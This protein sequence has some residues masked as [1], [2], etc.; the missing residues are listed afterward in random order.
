MVRQTVNDIRELHVAG[1]WRTK[2]DALLKVFLTLTWEDL[3]KYFF[4]YD[5]KELEKLPEDFDIRGLRSYHVGPVK[6][7]S[8]GGG[9]WHAIREEIVICTKGKV[10]WEC[11]DRNG[12]ANEFT[13][14]DGNG[15]WMPPHILH[16]YESLV[17]GTELLIVC[18]TLFNPD[19]PRTHDTYGIEDFFHLSK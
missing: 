9:E 18:N 17:D 16:T 4:S 11:Q 12:T 3:Q 10:L 1:P 14:Q 8:Q 19:N 15:V 5:T 6:E 13:L 2:S 7:G